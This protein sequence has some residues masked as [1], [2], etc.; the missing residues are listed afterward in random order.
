MACLLA[1]ALAS[2]VRAAAPSDD[3]RRQIEML[4]GAYYTSV[5]AEDVDKVVDLHH[6]ENSFERDKMKALA[7]QAFAVADSQ[8]EVVRIQSI[9]LYPERGI[10]MVRV[11]VDFTL[12]SLD[13]GDSLS[14][15]QESAIVVVNRGRGWRIGKVARAADFDLTA[16]VSQVAA[17]IQDLEEGVPT[18]P[19]G[20]P[21]TPPTGAKLPKLAVAAEIGDVAAGGSSQATVSA[22]STSGGLTFFALRRKTTGAC[23]VVAGVEG[24]SPGDTVL[25]AFPDFGAAQAA[26]AAGCGRT[27][28]AATSNTPSAVRARPLTTDRLYDPDDSVTRGSWGSVTR[29]AGES[30]FA[31]ASDA[32]QPVDDGFFVHPGSGGPTEIVYSHDG[33]PVT[34][35]GRGTVID[36][37]DYCGSAGTVSF[38][39]HGNGSELW[40][41][42]LVR[43]GGPGQS[44]AVSLEGVSEIRL[45]SSDGGNGTGEDWAAWLDLEI[46][47]S[48]TPQAA[49]SFAAV[50]PPPTDVSPILALPIYS[51]DDS[52]TG[53]FVV[54][55]NDGSAVFIDRIKGDPLTFRS[56][57]LNHN[58]FTVFGHPLD[59]PVKPG[60][61]LA[62]EIRATNGKVQGLFIVDTSTGSAAYLTDAGSE[63][64]RV[65]VRRI[66]GRPA[67][68]LASGDG[69]FALIMR[70]DGSGSTDG[71]YL[72]HATTGRC[73]YFAHIDDMD[74]ETE[75]E[76]AKPW[77]VMVGRVAAMALQDGS[78]ATPEALL[79]DGGSGL[80]YRV[81]GLEH[82]PV[83]VTMARQSINFFDFFPEAPTVP[84]VD[85]FVLA[86]SFAGNGATDSVF[87]VDAGSGRM[88]VLNDVRRKTEMRFVGF[89]DD[90]YR[91]FPEVE[92]PRGL[93]AVP[94]V[95]ASGTTDGVW[96]FDFATD[97]VIFLENVLAPRNLRI[98][99]V[100]RRVQ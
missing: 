40:N 75:V 31:K 20:P 100:N 1:G 17:R 22:A 97:E 3:E 34:L 68:A 54:K 4:I 94:K 64:H 67:A 99:R 76:F 19:V 6:W 7:E 35:R 27:Q 93:T 13:G 26:L 29:I 38:A 91:Y 77:P 51:G 53:L 95:S 37:V 82:R 79:V 87:V 15:H 5:A 84:T 62:G 63:S 32:G 10:G 70:R 83:E 50:S 55:L 16:A 57:A 43:H 92:G 33:S 8:F 28:A 9:D 98:R 36:C 47:N 73:A 96:V 21:E 2:T 56:R 49:P 24:I 89:T 46:V 85:R 59:R 42:G 90:I 86:P 66:N 14:G 71:A 23:E 45:I 74:P 41:S 18:A 61:I 60:E 80:V 39:I 65:T 72:Y 25:G 30:A 78:E 44:F 69:N 58:L 48:T 11:G 12:T 88:A 52:T 81:G